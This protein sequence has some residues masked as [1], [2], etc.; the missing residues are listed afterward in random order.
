LSGSQQI[1]QSLERIHFQSLIHSH[2]QRGWAYG[3]VINHKLLVDVIVKGDEEEAIK[4]IIN[5]VRGGLESE[6]QV[7][8]K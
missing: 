5:H 6:L 4:E 8:N 2:A 1:L 7:F 3:S